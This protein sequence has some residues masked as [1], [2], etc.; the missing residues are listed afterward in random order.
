MWWTSV[1]ETCLIFDQVSL[2]PVTGRT[3]V[4]LQVLHLADIKEWNEYSKLAFCTH[5][6]ARNTWI[7]GPREGIRGNGKKLKGNKA[8][9]RKIYKFKNL[10]RYKET[11]QKCNKW[12]E[13]QKKRKREKEKQ[14]LPELETFYATGRIV[15]TWTRETRWRNFE[16]IFLRTSASVTCINMNSKIL[17]RRVTAVLTVKTQRKRISSHLKNGCPT[18]PIWYKLVCEQNRFHLQVRLHSKFIAKGTYR[19]LKRLLKNQTGMFH[20]TL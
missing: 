13:N 7:A 18:K 14:V 20:L 3:R 15:T 16:N 8:I 9:G 19:L 5:L 10:K 11:K 17:F 4:L 1:S 2:L 12:K 6:V